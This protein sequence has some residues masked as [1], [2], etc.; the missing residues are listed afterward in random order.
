VFQQHNDCHNP[1]R[2]DYRC[3]HCRKAGWLEGR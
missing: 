3:I 1:I 2:P